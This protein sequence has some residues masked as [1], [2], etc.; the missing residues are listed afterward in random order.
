M[1]CASKFNRTQDAK[2][3]LYLLDALHQRA[4]SAT[5]VRDCSIRVPT[6]VG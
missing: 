6:S 1:L 2:Q 4:L 5:T 3:F